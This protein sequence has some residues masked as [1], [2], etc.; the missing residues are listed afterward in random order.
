M[1]KSY[2][3]TV[4]RFSVKEQ[5]NSFLKRTVHIYKYYVNLCAWSEM[6]SCRS[7]AHEI[8]EWRLDFLFLEKNSNTNKNVLEHLAA[9]N[10]ET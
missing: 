10:K 4:G 7:P 6:P 1:N 9:Y 5:R 2:R 3:K 8:E